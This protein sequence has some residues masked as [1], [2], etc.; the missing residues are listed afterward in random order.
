MDQTSLRALKKA[1]LIVGSPAELARRVGSHLGRRI[2]HQHVWNW[3][4]RDKKVPDW[5]VLAIEAA[6]ERQVTRHLLRRDLY[7][8]ERESA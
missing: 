2:A 3:L 6:T 5:A 1:C 4:N 8:M 7:P